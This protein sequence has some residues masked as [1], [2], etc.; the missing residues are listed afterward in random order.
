MI[1]DALIKRV[2]GLYSRVTY[3]S[4]YS[5]YKLPVGVSP[6]AG[7]SGLNS[8]ESDDDVGVFPLTL[9]KYGNEFS[10]LLLTAVFVPSVNPSTK[11]VLVAF[12]P[13]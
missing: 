11:N 3:V 2:F 1:A 10:A 6:N 13:L 7:C 5:V 12:V 9:S 4:Q 8:S